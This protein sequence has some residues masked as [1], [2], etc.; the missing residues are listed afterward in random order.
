M[1]EAHNLDGMY[2]T[3]KDK[4]N[5]RNGGNCATYHT[6]GWWYNVCTHSDLNGLYQ[7]S[8]K[9][10]RKGLFWGQNNENMKSTKMMIRSTE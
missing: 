7:T 4:D 10:N 2:F 1:I 9:S 6:G 3:T 5:D 8:N